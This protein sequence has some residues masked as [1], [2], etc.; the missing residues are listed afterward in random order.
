M[1]RSLYNRFSLNRSSGGENND[2]SYCGRE[3]KLCI[4]DLHLAASHSVGFNDLKVASGNS[5]N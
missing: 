1:S 4:V 3:F 5:M 2:S